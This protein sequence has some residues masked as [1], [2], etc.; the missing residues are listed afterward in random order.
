MPLPLCWL[1]STFMAC[2]EATIPK[3]A[4]W[5]AAAELCRV[6]LV[7][8]VGTC[9]CLAQRYMVLALEGLLGHVPGHHSPEGDTMRSPKVVTPPQNMPGSPRVLQPPGDTVRGATSYRTPPRQG[10]H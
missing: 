1:C 6:L 2:A 4:L 9:Q 8:V 5:T 10:G 3:Q 7:A